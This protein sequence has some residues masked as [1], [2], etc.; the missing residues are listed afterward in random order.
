LEFRT[1]SKNNKPFPLE[2]AGIS[3]S[4]MH[5]KASDVIEVKLPQEAHFKETDGMKRHQDNDIKYVNLENRAAMGLRAYTDEFV[6]PEGL[7]VLEIA[8]HHQRGKIFV[9]EYRRFGKS[10]TGEIIEFF[11]TFEDAVKYIEGKYGLKVH[12]K[13]DNKKWTGRT[14]EEQ[15]QYAE[16]R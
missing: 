14:W 4:D 7:I 13:D 6:T 15:I 9:E 10:T 16:A 1:S 12:L 3:E 5:E 8:K 2:P 11:D